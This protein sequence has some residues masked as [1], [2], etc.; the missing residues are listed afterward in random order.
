M[1]TDMAPGASAAAATLPAFLVSPEYAA[2]VAKAQ[3]AAQAPKAGV[4]TTEFWLHIL[5]LAI[6]AVLQVAGQSQNLLVI[7]AA[8]VAA[9][10]YT[11]ARTWVKGQ[12]AVGAAAVSAATVAA[13]APTP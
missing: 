4:V 1:T 8:Q 5:A 9:S 3:I 12:G 2:A 11:L 13:T 7:A 10:V 6:P